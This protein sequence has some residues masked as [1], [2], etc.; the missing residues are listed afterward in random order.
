MSIT[1]QSTS[2]IVVEIHSECASIDFQQSNM[3]YSV[4]TVQNDTSQDIQSISV[5]HL[6]SLVVDIK[7]AV[8]ALPRYVAVASYLHRDEQK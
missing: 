5:L 4:A 2:A 8:C 7:D 6:D 3:R 1:Y